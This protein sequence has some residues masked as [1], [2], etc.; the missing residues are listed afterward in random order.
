[1]TFISI[2]NHDSLLLHLGQWFALSSAQCMSLASV[3]PAS[4]PLLGV[5]VGGLVYGLDL[6]TFSLYDR[7]SAARSS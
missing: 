2:H 3:S 4:M 5:V 1:M 6:F 7:H